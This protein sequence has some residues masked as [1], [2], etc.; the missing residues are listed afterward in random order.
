V[1]LLA[2]VLFYAAVVAVLAIVFAVLQRAW[3]SVRGARRTKGSIVVDL[4]YFAL[5]PTLT[6]V[7]TTVGVVAAL[8]PLALIAGI[9]IS[10]EGFQQH[11]TFISHQ[12]LGLQII[13]F[14]LLANFVT[15]W[16]HRAFHHLGWLWK[17][18]SVHHSSRTLDW[19]S[20]VRVHPLNSVFSD[21]LTAAPI[22]LLGFRFT[23]FA[24][25][26]PFLTFYAILLHANLRWTY[27]PLRY[28]VAS[29]C[30]HRWH[31]TSE[32]FGLNKNFAG[33]FPF[34]DVLFGTFYMPRG[35]Q[36]SHFGI[37]GEQPPGNIFGQLVY[38]FRRR[39]RPATTSRATPGEL[40]PA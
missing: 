34:V 3:P 11:T 9:P 33:I 6:R 38:P 36:P 32:E 17:I 14:F 31:H 25:Y 1:A 22:L 8:I 40:A 30:F 16:S 27:G 29:P 24:A 2:R 5:A 28:V 35:Q 21:A 37:A 12:P 7:M 4:G 26:V 13:E 39:R 19:L 15:Y 10:R 18:H 23:A 20:A